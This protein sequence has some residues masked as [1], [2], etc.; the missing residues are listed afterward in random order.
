ML[1]IRAVQGHT[2]KTINDEELLTEIK[3]P[4]KY[5]EVIHGTYLN[6]IE[7]IMKTGL[8]KMARNHV[9]MALGLPGKNGVV[10]GMRASCEVL[11]EVNL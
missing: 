3:D 10:S 2:I 1:Y 7:A 8:N 11:V 4:F 9:H 6:C 5:E